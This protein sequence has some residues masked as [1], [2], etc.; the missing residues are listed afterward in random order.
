M[1]E[2]G[3]SRHRPRGGD[4]PAAGA[5]QGSAPRAAAARVVCAVRSH[6]RSLTDALNA[7]P[8]LADERDLAL[9]R[10]LSF[11]TLRLLPR[12]D[13]LAGVLLRRPLKAADADLEALLLI[14]LYQLAAMRVP[15]HAAVAA[16]VGATRGLQK[17]WAAGLLNAV[18][19][20]FQREQ[21]QLLE[22]V[23]ANAAAHW[24]FPDWLLAR[25]RTAW[26]AQWE[27][28][29]EASNTRAPMHLRVNL[30]GSNRAAYLELLR[31]AGINA[32]PLADSDCG[33]RLD[34]P[35]PTSRLPGFS[36]GLVSVQDSGAQRAARLVDPRPG[37]RVLDACAAPG[38]K[39]AHLLEHAGAGIDLTALDIDAAR[40][41]PL[42]ANLARLGL[43]ARVVV[44]DAA[45]PA[46]AWADQT[47]Q[48]IL[49][50]APCSATGVIRRHPDIK[51]LRRDSDIPVL[52]ATQASMLDA[53]WPLLAPGG[54]MLY[55]TCSVLP[56]ENQ[57]Q[58][59]AFLERHADAHACPIDVPWGIACEP[60]R[61]L[62]PHRDDSDGFYYALVEK[63][64]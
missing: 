28:I 62:L 8:P 53:I 23:D 61:Q 15:A 56:E 5:S 29:V 26:P 42:R 46:G 1:A 38:G 35:V 51:R 63:R 59:R 20:R 55:A 49:L 54:R 22:R 17:P 10:E 34:E 27:A 2:H 33:L 25:L 11:G 19:R 41:E 43:Q 30:T 47:Y 21:A 58:V 64:A 13:A 37:E 40:L 7:A 44:G 16:T 18:L 57:E 31:G 32:T 3:V 6:G 9:L 48:R 52:A 45:H 24:L 14:G 50:D 36:D 39:T 4:D 12:L 60:G